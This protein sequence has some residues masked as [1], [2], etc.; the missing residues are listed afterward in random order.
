MLSFKTSEDES[1]NLFSLNTR[2]SIK[3]IDGR[4]YL[5][6]QHLLNGFSAKL[7]ESYHNMQTANPQDTGDC[8]DKFLL[9][10]CL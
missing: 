7:K 9:D 4:I 8:D 2:L 6:C 10:M 1:V 3:W 5:N